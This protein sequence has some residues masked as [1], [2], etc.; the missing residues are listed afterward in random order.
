MT[1]G[2]LV[3]CCL[4]RKYMKFDS[5]DVKKKGSMRFFSNPAVYYDKK[6]AGIFNR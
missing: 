6:N 3:K 2:Q 5:Q 1:T 4:N